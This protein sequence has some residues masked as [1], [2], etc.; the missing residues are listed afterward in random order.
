MTNNK[1]WWNSPYE[2]L[3]NCQVTVKKG[4]KESGIQKLS[5]KNMERV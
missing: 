1:N 2:N 4:E 5:N 3:K